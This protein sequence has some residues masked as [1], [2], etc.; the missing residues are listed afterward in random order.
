MGLERYSV[1][2]SNQVEISRSALQVGALTWGAVSRVR[3]FR[4]S[5]GWSKLR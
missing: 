1:M 3:V 5:R 2:L 4:F